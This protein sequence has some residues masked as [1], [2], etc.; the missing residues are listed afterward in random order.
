MSTPVRLL[1]AFGRPMAL[2]DGTALPSNASGIL[3][4]GKDENSIARVPIVESKLSA[5]VT[6]DAPSYGARFSPD[7]AAFTSTAPI[8][9][10]K[11]YGHRATSA[12]TA[13]QLIEANTVADMF[14]S[15]ATATTSFLVASTSAN[16]A[17][18]GTGIRTINIIYFGTDG[19]RYI[20]SATMNGVSNVSV[21]LARPAVGVQEV[22]ST[23]AGTGLSAAGTITVKNSA[24]TTTLGQIAVGNSRTVTSVHP[25]PDGKTLYLRSIRLSARVVAS[26][27]A[28]VWQPWDYVNGTATGTQNITLEQY[29]VAVTSVVA[30]IIDPPISLKAPS[31]QIGRLWLTV[32]PDATTAA[33]QYASYS[34]YEV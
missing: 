1:D 5:R 23:S 25:V 6:I 14:L 19:K 29:R 22:Y 31:G 24:G 30:F 9:T 2:P 33:D 3:R 12:V 28:L 7:N 18:A 4:M 34:I 15:I 11:V 21:S 32:T 26:T 13:V 27:M 10:R 17:A 16:D 20:T 8:Y